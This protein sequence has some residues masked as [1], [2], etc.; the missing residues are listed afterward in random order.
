MIDMTPSSASP[1]HLKTLL[2]S[3][4]AVLRKEEKSMAQAT[5]RTPIRQ[6]G[7]GMKVPDGVLQKQ[8]LSDAATA[9]GLLW[10]VPEV[11][12]MMPKR[13]LRRA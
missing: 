6:L 9:L 7:G 10:K 4:L 5:A 3:S 8:A 1:Q 11:R 2:E 12:G 13:P